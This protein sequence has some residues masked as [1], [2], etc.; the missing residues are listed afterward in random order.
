M[1]DLVIWKAIWEIRYPPAFT[2]V[3]KKGEIATRLQRMPDMKQWRISDTEVA[4]T[5]GTNT[6]SLIVALGRTAVVMEGPRRYG[7]FCD[8]AAD[9]SIEMLNTLSVQRIGRL[10]L[11]LIQIAERK[12]FKA[13]LA[14]MREQLYTLEAGD[15]DIIGGY[16]QGMAVSLTLD[17]AE[18]RANFILAPMEKEQLTSF[19][20]SKQV[21]AELPSAGLL[22]DF[23]LYRTEPKLFPKSYKKDLRDF[24]ISGGEQVQDMSARFVDRYGGFL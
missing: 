10:G 20:E 11:R 22:L 15:W 2:L 18:N 8:P 3:D 14:K 4:F 21:S 17:L 19:F 24:L 1:T 23:D 9:L 13:L 12:N 6:M 16:P 5:N 7:D